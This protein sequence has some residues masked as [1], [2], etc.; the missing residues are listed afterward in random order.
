M[1]VGV[2]GLP[3]Q[4]ACSHMPGNTLCRYLVLACLC[5]CTLPRTCV[6]VAPV[7][8]LLLHC[9]DVASALVL[10]FALACVLLAAQAIVSCHTYVTCA[11]AITL[12]LM[13]ELAF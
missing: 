5:I 4:L 10:M 9:I 12:L 1:N 6:D 8:P 7:L 3:L 11:F 13:F 2:A